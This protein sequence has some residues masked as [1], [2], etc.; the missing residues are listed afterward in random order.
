MGHWDQALALLTLKSSQSPHLPRTNFPI[1][2]LF[3]LRFLSIKFG[4][5][6]SS[7][8]PSRKLG[9]PRPTRFPDI[10]PDKYGRAQIALMENNGVQGSDRCPSDPKGKVRGIQR[11]LCWNNYSDSQRPRPYQTLIV[12]I[13]APPACGACG[14][15]QFK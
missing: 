14:G 15:T 8:Y 5:N 9:R 2:S 1:H 10:F 3:R 11:V 12:N 4:L 6:S 13:L 7:A